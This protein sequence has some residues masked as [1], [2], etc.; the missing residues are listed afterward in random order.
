MAN[1]NDLKELIMAAL[2]GRPK[3]TAKEL[4]A[5]LGTNNERVKQSLYCMSGSEVRIAGYVTNT[6]KK[7]S[8][9]WS[10]MQTALEKEWG[11]KRW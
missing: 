4:S 10:L 3:Q 7:E 5:A 6:A 11:R 1:E 2:L 8:P 9:V